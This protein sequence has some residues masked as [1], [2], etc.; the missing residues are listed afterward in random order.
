MT[1]KK[2]LKFFIPILGLF[3]LVLSLIYFLVFWGRSVEYH[4]LSAIGRFVV[5]SGVA[6]FFVFWFGMLA[7]FFENKHLRRRV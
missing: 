2:G 6:G 1:E 7:H 3:F 4:E 5:I